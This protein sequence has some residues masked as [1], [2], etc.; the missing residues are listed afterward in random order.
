[1]KHKIFLL[2][3]FLLSTVTGFAQQYPYN[4]VNSSLGNLMRLSD[5]QTRS[6][7]PENFT[8]EKGKG[9][10]TTLEE[11]SAAYAARELGQGWKVNPYIIIEPGDTFVL[12]EIEGSGV[13]Q[14]IWMTPTGHWRYSV[15]RMYW[16]GEKE[17]S[18]EVPVGDFFAQGWERYAHIN[19]LAVTVNPGSGFNSF[20]QMPFSK[21]ARLTMTNMD[22]KPMRLYY[23]ID[24]VLTEIPEDAAYFHARFRRMNPLPYKEVYTIVDN[25]RGKGH[26]VGTYLAHGANSPGWW[27]EGEVKF[28]IDGDTG[29]PTIN[30]TGEED[31]FL[32]SY[33]YAATNFTTAYSGYHQISHPESDIEQRRFGQ[34]RWHIPDPVRF[35]EDLK[36]TIQSLGWQAGGR[37]LPLQD[38]LASVAYWYQ[39]EPHAPFPEFPA[40]EELTVSWSAPLN[41]LGKVSDIE[42]EPDKYNREKSALLDGET[43]SREFDDGKWLGFEGNDFVAVVDLKMIRAVQEVA[44]RFLGDQSEGIFHPGSVEILISGDGKTFE[45][46]YRENNEI[47]EQP[48]KRIRTFQ[49]PLKHKETRFVKIVAEN[50]GECPAWHS[51]AGNPARLFTDEIII[52]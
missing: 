34:Y 25:I 48:A 17:P 38:D 16:D 21:K 27:G 42:L 39:T 23:Q 3:G 10:M 4:G 13:I 32:G 15:L 33:G 47:L 7:S 22:K 45:S 46:V 50:I 51:K 11:G 5:A 35:E 43:G 49:T 52:R 8:G 40:R 14:H 1:M 30:G 9:G 6:I 44:V 18:V 29:F 24:Y 26:Y 20:W 41:H 12:G 36:I 31:Y 19:S 37:Y 28:Y 2:I